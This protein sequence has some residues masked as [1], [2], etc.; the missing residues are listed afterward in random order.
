[1]PK[2]YFVFIFENKKAT[3][4]KVLTFGM[5]GGVLSGLFIACLWSSEM[6]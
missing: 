1:M 3:K 4:V 5:D 2:K 6:L